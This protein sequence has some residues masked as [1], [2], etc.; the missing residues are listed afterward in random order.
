MKP[1]GAFLMRGRRN[2]ALLALLFA[3]LP[4]LNWLSVIIMALVTLRKGAKEGALILLCVLMP[5]CILA[6]IARDFAILYNVLLTAIIVWLLAIVLH[7][8]HDWSVV[9]L[10][11]VALGIV[12]IIAVHSYIDD[13]NAWW[14]QRMLAY[15]QQVSTDMHVNTVQQKQV[16][17]H[18]SKIATGI[19][20][21][22]LL[23]VNLLWLLVARYWQ[24]ILYNPGALRAELHR[25]RMPRW[26][27]IVLVLLGL[28][29][30][31]TQFMVIVDLLPIAL[32]A[33]MLAGLSLVHFIIA[34][35]KAHWLWLLV[36]Y[37][38]LVFALPYIGMALVILALADSL[39]NLRQ[40]YQ[41]VS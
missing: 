22:L 24:A 37:I 41:A 2:A 9:L 15:L 14:Q 39:L 33:F 40:R 16:V 12:G 29:G 1:F 32:L 11:G 36:F 18:L 8:S 17:M 20:A 27:S 35:R 28:A 23:A 26:A 13:I 30:L 38:I 31:L 34:A 3:L 25:I 21:T 5:A 10:V 6:L 4:F 19:Q 7:K